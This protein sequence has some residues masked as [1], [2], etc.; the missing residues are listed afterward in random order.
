MVY[1]DRASPDLVVFYSPTLFHG[2]SCHSFTFPLAGAQHLA[3]LHLF[4][5]HIVPPTRGIATTSSPTP[6]P[7]SASRRIALSLRCIAF[8]VSLP[9]LYHLVITL[10]FVRRLHLRVDTFFITREDKVSPG[11]ILSY[12]PREES[13][14]QLFLSSGSCGYRFLISEI[15]VAFLSP[16]DDLEINFNS[17]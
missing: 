6:R 2:S 5:Y 16:F 13:L 3:R 1:G 12:S 14:R 9:I 8:I 7:L 17:S 4:L 11:W 15:S 10:S